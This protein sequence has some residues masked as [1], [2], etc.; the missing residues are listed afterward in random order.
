VI[1]IAVAMFFASGVWQ[2]AARMGWEG[3]EMPFTREMRE[4]YESKFAT[5]TV[6]P[7]FRE[8][9][10]KV[11]TQIM[12]AQNRY[13][14]VA[15]QTKVPWY[16]IGAI[17]NLECSGDFGCHLH[18][19]DTLRRRTVNVPAGRP[20]KGKPPFKWEESAVDALT[21]DGFTTWTDWSVGGTL[22]KLEGYNGMGYRKRGIPSPYLWSGSQH[23]ARGKY[24]ADGRFDPKAI[25][26]Q[27]GA[28]VVLKRMD[29]QALIELT[30]QPVVT[31]LASAAPAS[32]RAPLPAD[33][34]CG[35]LR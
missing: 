4:E 17:H 5:A 1:E 31:P 15:S 16:V 9:T 12:K 6:R 7:E 33:H 32:N 29:D 14:A 24:V 22:Y 25:S 27:L 10:E 20:L 30:P 35:S 11:V 23:Y 34:D 3:E 21:L 8:R 26:A 28:A 19:G 13:K 2:D 18:N